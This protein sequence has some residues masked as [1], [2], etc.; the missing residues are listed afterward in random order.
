[1]PKPPSRLSPCSFAFLLRLA[2][3][4]LRRPRKAL[5]LAKSAWR[6]IQ[7]ALYYRRREFSCLPTTLAIRITNR[8][9]LRC[10]QC[11]QWGAQGVYHQGERHAEELSFEDYKRLILDNAKKIT[12]LYFWGGEPFLRADMIDIIRL[13]SARGLTTQL[14]TNGTL[15]GDQAEAIV[16]SGLDVIYVSLD[17]P[18]GINDAIRRGQDSYRKTVDGLERLLAA[19]ARRRSILPLV[20]L[21]M[22]ITPENQTCITQT[23]GLAKDLKVDIFH[24]QFGIFTS[25][26]LERSSAALFEAA[27]G[28]APRYWQGFVRDVSRLDPHRIQAQVNLVSEDARRSRALIYRQTPSFEVDIEQYY[29]RPQ[30]TMRTWKCDIP[31][32]Y[33]QVMPDGEAVYCCDFPDFAAGN[34]LRE[35]LD[36]VWNNEK[37]RRFRGYIL[38]NGIFPACSRCDTHLED[39]TKLKVIIGAFLA[40]RPGGAP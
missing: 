1:M 27:F 10:L 29:R 4:Y 32:K 37:S 21:C 26:E 36:Q 18:E 14:T 38:K 40:G 19:R 22:T 28:F 3:A 15:I 11:G 8:C 25:A 20:G 24:L 12:H 17:G 16:D 39:T 35:G 7:V 33:M 13:A 5:N 9:N 34:V 6:G 31:W 2:W 30:E 23:Y